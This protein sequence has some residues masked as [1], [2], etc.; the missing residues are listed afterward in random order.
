MSECGSETVKKAITTQY[1]EPRSETDHYDW[2][3]PVFRVVSL[4]CA[5]SAGLHL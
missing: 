4:F 1:T 3:A 5:L 2:A